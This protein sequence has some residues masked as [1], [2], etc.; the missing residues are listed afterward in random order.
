MGV[1]VAS[2]AGYLKIPLGR[3]GVSWIVVFMLCFRFKNS[4][5]E[6]AR[7][8]KAHCSEAHSLLV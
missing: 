7:Y 2:E 3:G 5:T 8:R 6:V 1:K 4:V